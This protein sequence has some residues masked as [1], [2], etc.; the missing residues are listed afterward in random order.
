MSELTREL[1]GEIDDATK[2]TFDLGS[3]RQA[4]KKEGLRRNAYEKG[5]REV[6]RIAGKPQARELAAWI[7]GEIRAKERFPS[8]RSVRK[9]GAK[10]CRESGHEISTGSWLGA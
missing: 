2:E 1:L 8:A 9:R 4:K 6:Q 7:E 10:I 3:R 5:L